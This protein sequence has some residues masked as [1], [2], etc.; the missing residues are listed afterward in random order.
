MPEADK[1]LIFKTSGNR[2]NDS[3]QGR[4]ANTHETHDPQEDGED[5]IAPEEHSGIRVTTHISSP[6]AAPKPTNTLEYLSQ[7][8]EHDDEL[9]QLVMM[10]HSQGTGID[11]NTL[12]SQ[13]SLFKKGYCLGT[14]WGKCA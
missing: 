12:M 8:E 14:L 3:S 4:R 10:Q 9:L 6:A 5:E 13:P 7:D 11:I 2:G 1:I